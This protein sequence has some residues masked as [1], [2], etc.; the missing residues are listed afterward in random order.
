MRLVF[1]GLISKLILFYSC[2]SDLFFQNKALFYT[3][4]V[5]FPTKSH[6]LS[7]NIYSPPLIFWIRYLTRGSLMG[8]Y[9]HFGETGVLTQRHRSRDCRI[10]RLDGV[11]SNKTTVGILDFRK[12]VVHFAAGVNSK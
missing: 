9:P 7:L 12:N 1:K 4:C 5:F 3:H 10:Y 11:I 8:R 2:V 6:F